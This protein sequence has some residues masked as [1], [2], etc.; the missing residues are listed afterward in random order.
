MAE[1]KDY[2]SLLRKE[3]T[4]EQRR[5]ALNQGI[6]DQ[7]YLI[8]RA[9][10]DVDILSGEKTKVVHTI[11]T[12]CQRERWVP[13]MP[14]DQGCGKSF[15]PAPFGFYWQLDEAPPFE[16]EED[17]TG[18]MYTGKKSWCPF[19]G[20]EVI[21]LH[22][23]QLRY[24]R[25]DD[26]YFHSVERIDKAVVLYT[27]RMIRFISKE[28]GSQI[29]WYPFEALIF[30]KK[31]AF[32]CVAYEKNFW[33]ISQRLEWKQRSKFT[34][35]NGRCAP[36]VAPWNPEEVL[37]GTDLEN[38]RLDKIMEIPEAS[39]AEYLRYWQKNQNIEALAEA[40]GAYL[41]EKACAM[42]SYMDAIMD[43]TKTKPAA[44]LKM[45]RMEF[46]T[47]MAMKLNFSE[48]RAYQ[49]WKEREPVDM[50]SDM[51]WYRR[52]KLVRDVVGMHIPAGLRIR[53]VIAYLTKQG[54]SSTMLADY[55]R[56]ARVA[57]A[58][59][60]D[61]HVAL[62]RNLRR[63]HDRLT[64]QMNEIR[65]REL[66][67]K[68]TKE[69]AKRE[70]LFKQRW[71]QLKGLSFR[72]NGLIIR[73]AA[74]ERELVREGVVLNHCVATYA[75]RMA[76]GDTAIFFIRK[77]DAPDSPFFTLELDEKNL[78]V[79][80]NRGKYNCA[81]TPEVEQFEK[82]WLAWLQAINKKEERKSA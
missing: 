44:M 10:W 37:K 31:K 70:P 17:F 62:P 61:D 60:T 54:E 2:A 55:W 32:R 33:E 45:N 34:N 12:C 48:I 18:E 78:K 82:D 27:W 35:P 68:K 38:S 15:A 30:E 5:W 46:K 50:R 4:A 77:A 20:S 8:Y 21:A 76:R 71:K 79:R 39:A 6:A 69:M 43:M 28:G 74:N 7:E 51:E 49:S 52:E 53:R 63:E 66:L 56:M 80:Q 65:A 14:I 25:K 3:P 81:R 41:A 47:C 58:D 9:D 36:L 75:E 19:C 64:D 23:G 24:G 22:I 40:G 13:Y 59:L 67:A 57:E 1:R 26:A 11:C 72:K 73:P 16:T 42:P 29:A